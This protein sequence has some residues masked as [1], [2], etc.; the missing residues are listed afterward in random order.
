MTLQPHIA[1]S[2][3]PAITN[4]SD[5]H[6]CHDYDI[7][8]RSPVGFSHVFISELRFLALQSIVRACISCATPL[9]LD[10][11]TL[12]GDLGTTQQ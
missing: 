2:E 4:Y 7:T 3:N 11:G 8:T 10:V 5:N 6:N 9:A 12:R 1:T